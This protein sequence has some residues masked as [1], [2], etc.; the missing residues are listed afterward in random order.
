M[1]DRL[2][3]HILGLR[4]LDFGF[5]PATRE[6]GVCSIPIDWRSHARTRP[7]SLVF[8]VAPLPKIGL[9]EVSDLVALLEADERGLERAA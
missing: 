1:G 3:G 8:K 5:Y 6:G 2:P 4:Y 7:A 9:W